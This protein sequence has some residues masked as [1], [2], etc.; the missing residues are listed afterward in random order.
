MAPPPPPSAAGDDT[1]GAPPSAPIRLGRRILGVGAAV[2]VLVAVAHAWLISDFLA[3]RL[4]QREA[5][6]SRDFVQNVLVADGSFDVL[7]HPDE[8]A[9]QARFRNSVDH[10]AT[11]HGVLRANVYAPD[12]TV[13]WSTDAALTGRRFG[14]NDELD[15][16]MRGELQVHAGRIDPHERT[17]H[18]HEGLDA[19]A[20]FYVETYIPIRHPETR[21]VL[22]VVELYKAPQAL[23]EAVEAGTRQVVL[24]SAAGALLLFVSLAGLIRRADRTMQAQHHQLLEAGTQ[25]VMVELATAVAHNVRNPL[26]SIRSA[27]ELMQLEGSDQERAAQATQG[28]AEILHDV[29]RISQRLDALLRLSRPG[30]ALDLHEVALP[31]LLERL[32]AEHA[33][34][35]ARVGQTLGLAL[36]PDAPSRVRT[37]GAAL[38]QVIASLLANATEAL[39]PGG[40]CTLR[41]QAA[42]QSGGCRIE[43]ADD[44]PGMSAELQ[45]Q[46]MK[47]FFTTK[48]QGLGLG[49]PLAQ[50]IVA[51]LQGRLSLHGGPGQGTCVRIELPGA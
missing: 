35:F 30:V 47:P 26:A 41:A 46:V 51:R 48:P 19:R 13:R 40:T 34:R 5:E 11:L 32:H 27:A 37:D 21:A 36:H 24:M 9:L 15:D 39:G 25:A 49:L 20:S 50:R 43:V 33:A 18:E 4:F 3:A 14:D 42:P 31:A 28:A 12:G 16:A 23:T 45:R 17:K 44:G 22:G 6:I 2:I 7:A 29:D 10:L 8:P 1:P 38:S